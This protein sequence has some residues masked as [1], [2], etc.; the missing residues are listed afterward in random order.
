MSSIVI[1][2]TQAAPY[3]VD[4]LAKDAIFIAGTIKK[5]AKGFPEC[6]KSAKPAK[7]SYVVHTVDDKRYCVFQDRSEACFVTN[8]FP[9][10]MDSQVA[11]VQ[12]EGVLRNQSVRQWRIQGGCSVAR[13]P[14]SVDA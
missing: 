9:E 14:P 2:S 6:L 13:A 8:V 5:C 11:R 7:G 3:I 10:H 1:I 12:P 4:M